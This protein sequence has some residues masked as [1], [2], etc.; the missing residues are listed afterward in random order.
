MNITYSNQPNYNK[1]TVKTLKSLALEK[2]LLI[3]AK[4]KKDELINLL[5]N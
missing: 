2:G 4:I 5:S 1:L 3:P